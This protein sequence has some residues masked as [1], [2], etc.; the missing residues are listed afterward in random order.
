[1][2]EIPPANSDCERCQTE[3]KTLHLKTLIS[4]ALFGLLVG[5]NGCATQSAI[6]YAKGQPDKAWVNNLFGYGDMGP[7]PEYAPPG[8]KPKPQ[9]HPAYYCLLPLSVPIDVATSPFQLLWY[10]SLWSGIGR[11]Q[12]TISSSTGAASSGHG[13][14]LLTVEKQTT[15]LLTTR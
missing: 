8:P 15:P 9:P 6:Q 5:S 3:M 11:E 2:L 14:S 10:G 4:L 13:G 7:P 1:M 12:P